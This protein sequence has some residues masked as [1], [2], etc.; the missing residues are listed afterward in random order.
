M[1]TALT[2][3]PSERKSIICRA[4]AT[5]TLVW[6]S[7]VDAP[8]WGVQITRSWVN[9]GCFARRFGFENIQCRPGHFSGNGIIKVALIDD[10][11][12]GT[13]DDHHTCFHFVESRLV[14]HPTVFFNLG[15]CTLI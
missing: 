5:A 10:S 11:A 14:D 4:M 7:R 2:T 1:F 8:R 13:V 9:K 6:A 12:P 15:T 3:V